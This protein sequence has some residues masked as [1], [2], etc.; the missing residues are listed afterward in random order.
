MRKDFNWSKDIL[1]IFFVIIDKIEYVQL[2]LLRFI[3]I[4]W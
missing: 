1:E 4:S 2:D 3:F